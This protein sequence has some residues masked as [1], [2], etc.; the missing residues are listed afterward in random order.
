[1]LIFLFSSSLFL[2][3]GSGLWS[4][5]SFGGAVH[6]GYFLPGDAVENG[7]TFHFAAVTDLDKLSA[8]L[9]KDGGK[10]GKFRSVL[11]PGTIT[12]GSDNKYSV[13]FENIRE[14]IS[15]HNEGGRG[16]ELSELILFQNRLLSFDDRT[17][18]V[19]E[20]LNQGKGSDSFV[21]PRFVVTEGEG[22]TDKGMK[23]EWASVK[24]GELYMGS[25]GKEYTDRDGNIVNVNN[26]WISIIN[27]DGQ[28]RRED[29][30][31]RYHFIRKKLKATAPGYVINEA[32]SWSPHL[33]KWVFM[34]RRISS[35][36]YDDVKDEKMGAAKIVLVNEAFTSAEVI[37][38]KF[39]DNDPLHGFSTFAFVPGS[40]DRHVLAVRTV[41]EDCA[42]EDESL[43][44]QRSY[45]LV[46]DITTGDVLMEEILPPGEPLKFEGVEFVNMYTPEKQ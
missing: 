13:K 12:K 31:D 40:K 10:T 41:E 38:I 11:L 46:V 42:L 28:L 24:D 5:S 36:M 2:A 18:S 16:M 34:P 25:M 27:K 1:M 30:T 44:K 3:N 21:V 45:F 7:N 9:D 33:N 43:C 4:K 8:V 15:K 37:D 17:G 29:W 14:L 6:P 22:D 39:T 35:E 20:V 19:F 23:W 26:L 32:I